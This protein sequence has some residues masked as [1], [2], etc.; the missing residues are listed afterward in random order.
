M[1]TPLSEI[2][3]ALRGGRLGFGEDV[4]GIFA[5][6]M[7]ARGRGPHLTSFRPSETESIYKR[8]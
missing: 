1:Q 4:S 6:L 3:Y 8:L 5:A 7:A 2:A